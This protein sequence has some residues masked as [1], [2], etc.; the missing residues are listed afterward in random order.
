MAEASRN[1]ELRLGAG[2]N[3]KLAIRGPVIGPGASRAD[4][5]GMTRRS[6]DVA[7]ADP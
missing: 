5:L 3:R 2:H 7:I 4:C 1:P 6:V